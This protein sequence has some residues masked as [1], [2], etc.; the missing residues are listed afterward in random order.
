MND[1]L[2]I[3][4]IEATYKPGDSSAFHTHNADYALYVIEGSNTAFYAKD[5]TR[6]VNEMKTGSVNSRPADAQSVKNTGKTTVK[7]LLVEINRP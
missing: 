2:G 3:Q 4:I 7:V 1:S 6:M 5:G